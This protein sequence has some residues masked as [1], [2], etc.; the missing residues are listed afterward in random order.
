MRVLVLTLTQLLAAQL[1][2]SEFVVIH[3]FRFGH[4]TGLTQ[5]NLRAIVL[6]MV[7]GVSLLLAVLEV[8]VRLRLLRYYTILF[9][10]GAVAAIF[11]IVYTA[12]HIRI[13]NQ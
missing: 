5:G 2:C 9:V 13:D 10:V 8:R 12:P 1:V 11:Y 4:T 3:S 7:V 6:P